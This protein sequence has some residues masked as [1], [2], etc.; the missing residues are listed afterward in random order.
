L[1]YRNFQVIFNKQLPALPLY[2]PVYT[3]AVDRSVQGIRLGPL[4]D[5]AERLANLP[6][7]CLATKATSQN[8]TITN[9]QP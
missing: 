3:Y 5:P 2:Y 6:T 1:L 4:F 7:W 8:T 9:T